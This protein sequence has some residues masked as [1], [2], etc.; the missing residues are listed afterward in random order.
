M[1]FD[2]YQLLAVR[3]RQTPASADVPPV[4]PGC[5]KKLASGSLFGL[6]ERVPIMQQLIS[7]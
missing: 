3:T 6:F 4:V 7:N 2:E 5:C 1:E